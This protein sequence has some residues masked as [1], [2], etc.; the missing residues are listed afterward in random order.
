MVAFAEMISS[1][2]NVSDKDKSFSSEVRVMTGSQASE[3]VA[4][5]ENEGSNKNWKTD[6]AHS[7]LAEESDETAF[8]T[9]ETNSKCNESDSSNGPVI[10]QPP[11]EIDLGPCISS[12]ATISIVLPDS[13]PVNKLDTYQSSTFETN[14]AVTYLSV[15]RKRKRPQSR[16]KASALQGDF[17]DKFHI[18]PTT[19]TYSKGR[20][21]KRDKPSLVTNVTPSMVQTPAEIDLVG[22]MR[23]GTGTILL[24]LPPLGK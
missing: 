19:H 16:S 7:C 1:D 3:K 15:E 14:P 11:S 8:G 20:S 9:G 22:P 2:V 18:I 5:D 17:V 23:P 24:Q 10:V 12:N 13:S 21:R 4:T 6:N